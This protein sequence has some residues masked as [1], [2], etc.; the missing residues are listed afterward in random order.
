MTLTLEVT[1]TV[2]HTHL[3]TTTVFE[4]GSDW[5]RDPCDLD[6]GGHGAVAGCP[7]SAYQVWSS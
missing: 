5:S 3:R 2:R 4:H 7:P 1:A 6:L